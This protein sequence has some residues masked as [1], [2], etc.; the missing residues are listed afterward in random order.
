M[1]SFL[2]LIKVNR[3]QMLDRLPSSPQLPTHVLS[4]GQG[5]ECL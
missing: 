4:A 3:T 5:G 2:S 1:V